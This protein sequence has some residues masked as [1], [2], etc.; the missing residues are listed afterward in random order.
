VLVAL[1]WRVLYVTK[2][3]TVFYKF[4]DPH[5]YHLQ[6]NF[7][8]DG[9]GFINSSIWTIYRQME[10]GA[11][12]PPL[13]PLLLSVTS[14]FGGTGWTAHRVT[15]SVIGAA[16]VLVLGLV[17]RR[18]AGPRAG[19]LVAI[20]AAVYPNLWM[21][22]GTLFPEGLFALTI[23]LTIL[24]A[25]RFR[26]APTLPNAALLGGMIALAALTRG[27]ALLLIAF[28]AVPLVLWTRDLAWW[29]P[30]VRALLV[31]VAV[32]VAVIAPWTIRNLTTFEEPIFMSSNSDTALAAANCDAV[33]SG[34]AIGY[35]SFGCQDVRGGDESEG[36]RVLRKRAF[37]YI[38]N[39]LD[40]VPVVVAARIGRAWQ[41]YKPFQN[42]QL[43]TGEGRPHW[44]ANA[45]LWTYWL[46]L[47]FAVFGG[48]A[49]YRRRTTLIPILAQAALVTVTA[50]AVY[51]AIRF[52]V[53]A[54]VIV[55]VLAGVGIDALL[56]R[57][58]SHQDQPATGTV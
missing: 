53:P 34:G 41:V 35:W 39:N 37:D 27:E 44:A 10:P 6:A 36:A 51:G 12:H 2:I 21:I 16:T 31:T 32:T 22:D 30:R 8:A 4:G 49:T 1:A 25:Y 14:W 57:L 40:R 28:L 52:A 13:Y 55:I 29:W 17:G 19:L 23:G 45:G 42:T 46:L 24:T 58:P 9:H 3:D 50:G 54:D 5:Y 43:S 48:L 26:S 7:L 33:Y 56:Q 15:S 47:P 38:G 20:L 18:L 11:V